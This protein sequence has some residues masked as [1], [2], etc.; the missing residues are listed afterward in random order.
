[1]QHLRLA[2][3][4]LPLAF[5]L[6]CG[7]S[8]STTT[9]SPV[10]TPTFTDTTDLTKLPVGDSRYTTTPTIGYIFTCSQSFSGGGASAVG[11]WLN[12]TSNTFDF[13]AKTVVSGTVPWPTHN[14]TITLAGTTRT[15]STNDLPNHNTGTFP[16]ASTD[17][18]YKY[19]QNPNSITTQTITYALPSTPTLATNPSCVGTG[20]IGFLLTG[21]VIYDGLDAGG[22]DAVAHELQDNCQGHP[23]PNGQYHYHSLTNCL[24][25]PGTGHSAL[26]GY[27]VDGF[28][29]FG[30]RGT[31]GAELTDADLDVCH[32]H[33]HAI[34]WDGATV[35]MYHY[36]ATREYPYS[37]GCYRGT[38][39]KATFV[40][41]A[42]QPPAH[43]HNHADHHD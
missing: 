29:I 6:G 42:T 7:S 35:T 14:Y 43:I 21:S 12:S 26:I 41:G 24:A 36:H 34:T 38:P 13:T 16:I 4:A 28:G 37:I 15:I 19:D 20:P 3:L 9:S 33:T 40:Y 23:Q 18:A 2:A 27:A 22:R 30:S 25:D 8:T 10:S 32:G 31:T 11:P 5:A 17:P 39:V 1:M